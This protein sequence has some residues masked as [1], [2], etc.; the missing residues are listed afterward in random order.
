MEMNMVDLVREESREPAWIL[1]VIAGVRAAFGI[2]WAVDAFLTWQPAFPSHYV[3]YLQNA[4][5]GQPAWILPW[6]QLWISLVT[7]SVGVFVILTRVLETLIALFLLVGFAR[8]WTYIVGAFFSLA[9]WS[10][11]EGFSG[12]YVT[13]AGNIGPALIYLVV[14]IILFVADCQ[15]GL[16]PYSVDYYIERR[17]SGWSRVAECSASRFRH[18][19]P[20]IL[21]WHAQAVVIS[22]I[23]VSLVLVFGSLE[24]ATGA[25]PATP[26]NA[27]AAV[28][29]LSLASNQPVSSPRDATLP[30]LLGQG[31]TV[32]LNI[33]S[34]DNTVEI[35]SGVN[36]QAWTFGGSVPGPV[37]H[38]RQGQTVNVAFTNKGKMQHSLDFHAAEVPPDKA[39]VNV[40]PGKSIHYSFVANVAGAFLYHCGTAPVLMH[41]ANGM[42]GAIIVDPLKPM[43]PADVSY[44]IVQ[45]EWYT[46]QV[47]GQT[48]TGNYTKMQAAT[49]DEV[50]FNGVAFQY[51]DHPLQVKSGQRVRIY[52]IDAGPN[53]ASSFHVIGEIFADV[54]PDGDPDH[55]LTGVSTYDVSP[56]AGAV[57][58]LIPKTPGNYP[59]VDHSMR[60]AGSGAVGV[61]QVNP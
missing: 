17:N 27:A 28:S 57:F 14:F 53:L 37:F 48:M 61:L 21:A 34:T 16:S 15:N 5:Q 47:Q 24:S 13:G 3:G 41:I 59:F 45:G 46:S 18:P 30:P 7:P 39:Y 11:A 38:L 51:R 49:P 12:P 43:P 23:L 50:V 9:I 20:R 32:N 33:E 22:A 19:S 44:V 25:S 52:M 56:G 4:S 2:I 1:P 55:V 6:F 29:P 26:Q 8:K 54:Y 42:Y 31:D 10:T 36:Y 35:A 60:A 40:D 58:D